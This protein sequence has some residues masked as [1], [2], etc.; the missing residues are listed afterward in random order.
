MRGACILP[1]NRQLPGDRGR[2][3]KAI[4]F[5]VEGPTNLT[6]AEAI[7]RYGSETLNQRNAAVSAM[8]FD[9]CGEEDQPIPSQE[10]KYIC[11]GRLKEA[12]GG[13]YLKNF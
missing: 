13:I 11:Q 3:A 9:D 5:Y 8:K 1:P 12:P 4:R 10:A 2:A 7:D 6:V